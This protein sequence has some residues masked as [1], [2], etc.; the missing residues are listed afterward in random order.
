MS[1]Y[2]E[3]VANSLK[4]F[5]PVCHLVFGNPSRES[6]PECGSKMP[7]DGWGLLPYPFRNNFILMEQLGRGGMGAV[8]KAISNETGLAVALKI[9]RVDRDVEEMK[10]RFSREMAVA[11]MLSERDKDAFVGVTSTDTMA[12]PYY[13]A[14]EFVDA[15]TLSAFIIKNGSKIKGKFVLPYMEAINLSTAIL[16][17]LSVA[18]HHK[19]VHMDIKPDNI[20]I[21]EMVSSDGK[22]LYHAKIA[23]LG[24][25]I[26]EDDESAQDDMIMGT[27]GYMSPEQILGED[28]KRSTDVFAVAA[29]MYEMIAGTTPYE[30]EAGLRGIAMAK[31]YL[32]NMKAGRLQP[33]DR[34]PPDVQS[35][36]KK[37][38]A[39]KESDRFATA[40]EF[41]ASLEELLTSQV[42]RNKSQL[43]LIHEQRDLLSERI[44]SVRESL[45][46]LL[47]VSTELLTIEQK[48]EKIPVDDQDIA[49]EPHIVKARLTRLTS[50]AQHLEARL[51][52]VRRN[53]A[54]QNRG[55]VSKLGR[56]MASGIKNLFAKKDEDDEASGAPFLSDAHRSEKSVSMAQIS[57]TTPKSVKRDSEVIKLAVKTP[58]K[59]LP[60]GSG[61]V[62]CVAFSPVERLLVTGSNKG[63]VAMFDLS[64]GGRP[65]VFQAH[66]DSIRSIAFDPFGKLMI[67][68][69]WDKSIKVW[70]V[71]T[72]KEVETLFG[73]TAGLWSAYFSSEGSNIV[74]ASSDES[75]RVWSYPDGRILH[76]VRMTNKEIV[77]M[78]ASPEGD[79]AF[80]GGWGGQ[81]K[82]WSLPDLKEIA[83]VIGHEDAVR[84]L[85]ISPDGR[86]LATGGADGTVKTWDVKTMKQIATLSG[87]KGWIRSIAVAEEGRLVATGSNDK[88]LR[89]WRA[90]GEFL[91]V[92]GKKM[93]QIIPVCFSDNGMMLASGFEPD[94]VAIFSMEKFARE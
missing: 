89:L 80:T 64:H 91:G 65:E 51:A 86:I 63:L 69:G 83:T 59:V 46:D 74:S 17:S 1:N 90:K 73:H 27:P 44:N 6:C 72:K 62:L 92:V 30:P 78:V 55:P 39:Y 15:P 56:K 54:M 36:L 52:A 31:G 45:K 9:A 48:L 23:D 49:L 76:Q 24:A 50:E 13:M 60:P 70:D 29:M 53:L 43:Q 35:L 42:E 28:V 16:G 79:M 58:A 34:I 25:C 81:I 84:A 66:D 57:S 93:P 3:N 68:A 18:H 87:H 19:I 20:F 2:E 32:K 47:Q 67:T 82:K 37:A 41:K 21:N 61:R 22:V 4:C 7:D 40:E 11:N 33:S 8:Y 75:F 5:C 88:T 38:L 10:H 94:T 12:Q 26:F 71:K 77:S 14:M 85:G